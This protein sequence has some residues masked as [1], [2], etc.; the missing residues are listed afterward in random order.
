[1]L[2]KVSKELSTFG[3]NHTGASG[4]FSE[5]PNAATPSEGFDLEQAI[6]LEV[7]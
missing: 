1:M 7:A 6:E 4:I 5:N 2:D 3:A